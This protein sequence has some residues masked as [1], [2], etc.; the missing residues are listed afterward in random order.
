MEWWTNCED[1]LRNGYVF[2]QLLILEQAQESLKMTA[3]K[4]LILNLEKSLNA[5]L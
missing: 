5:A 2:A 4:K 3:R 1:N